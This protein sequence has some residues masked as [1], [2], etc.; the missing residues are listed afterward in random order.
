MSFYET[1]DSTNVQ[2][3]KAADDGAPEGTLI[4]A[5]MQTDG[6]GRRGKTWNSPKG[7]N[8]YFTLILRPKYQPKQASMVTLVMALAV[9]AGI[10]ETCGLQ[11]GIKWPND[12]VA[13]GKKVCGILTEMHLK[14]C[15]IQDVLIGVGVNV[16]KQE[17]PP[18]LAETAVSLWELCGQE[19]S[20]ERLTENIL[21]A[22]EKYY[23]KFCEAE[24]L[25]LLVEEYNGLL[26]NADREVRVQD[27]REEQLGVARGINESGE[28]MV[29][30]GD[31]GLVNISAGIVSVRGINGYV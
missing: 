28:L 3:K 11:T 21:C 14:G 22:F 23:D 27:G 5:D 18:E 29:E 25:S 31:R 16:G 20:R 7:G 8:L 30:M 6:R 13:G 1:L 2:A 15:E 19:L 12:I 26:V 4:M 10:K 9:A 17:F 24:N